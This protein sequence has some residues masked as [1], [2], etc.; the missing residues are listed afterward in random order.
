MWPFVA[1]K[2][3]EPE[4][5][6][7][8]S[9][10][11]RVSSAPVSGQKRRNGRTLMPTPVAARPRPQRPSV[12]ATVERKNVHGRANSECPQPLGRLV[13][14]R[15][16]EVPRTTTTVVP[17]CMAC[18][19]VPSGGTVGC[20]PH[21]RKSVARRPVF[22]AGWASQPDSGA[23]SAGS[24]Y[25]RRIGVIT[26]PPAR[27]HAAVELRPRRGDSALESSSLPEALV[28]EDDLRVL[29]TR[30]QHVP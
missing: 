30:T 26:G 27:T 14:T 24:M 29:I 21:E 1:V 5:Q 12:A 8:G 6:A 10:R 23:V 28:V 22:R 2:Q 4:R 18:L 15:D 9:L 17:S 16:A 13:P 3:S 25:P 19:D 11:P 7:I 20:K